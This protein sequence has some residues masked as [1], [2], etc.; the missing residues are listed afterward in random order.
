MK[1]VLMFAAALA[2]LSAPALAQYGGGGQNSG[3][4]R[5]SAMRSAPGPDR[6]TMPMRGKKM[7][8]GKRMSKKQMM[9]SKRMR[10]GM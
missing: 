1:K 3:G 2:L 6:M 5:G 9:R 10:S 8:R 4:P 7:M